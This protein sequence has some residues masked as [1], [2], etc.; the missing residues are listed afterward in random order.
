MRMLNMNSIHNQPEWLYV[1]LIVL[2][3]DDIVMMMMKSVQ[4]STLRCS[5]PQR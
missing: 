1:S 5:V 4:A 3:D 2:G